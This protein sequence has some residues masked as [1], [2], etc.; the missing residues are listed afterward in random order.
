[1]NDPRS[2]DDIAHGAGR[3]DEQSL[4][5]ADW[6]AFRALA[7]R[8]LDVALDHAEGVRD[9][10]VWTPVPEKVKQALDEPVPMDPQGT[11][12]VCDD[13]TRLVLPYP[14]EIGRAHV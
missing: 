14:T 6:P 8:M 2:S 4:D 1:M 5:P 12:K 11:E 7:H 9:R 3:G 10:P 13:L